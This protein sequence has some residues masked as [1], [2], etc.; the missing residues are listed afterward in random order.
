MSLVENRSFK[1]EVYPWS[2]T[3]A[4][5]LEREKIIKN[6][7]YWQK[8]TTCPHVKQ[9]SDNLNLPSPF[10]SECFFFSLKHK[11]HRGGSESGWDDDMKIHSKSI[12]L[13]HY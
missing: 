2:V 8:L 1:N 3:K 10:F 11:I 4:T 13:N 12:L 7:Y 9:P 5:Q 6:T